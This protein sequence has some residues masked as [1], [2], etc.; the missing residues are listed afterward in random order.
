MGWWG[1][2]NHQDLSC[3]PARQAGIFRFRGTGALNPSRAPRCPRTADADGAGDLS[4]R[5]I[6]EQS[7]AVGRG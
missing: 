5:P 3:F 2:A 7:R 1:C 4:G 6:G